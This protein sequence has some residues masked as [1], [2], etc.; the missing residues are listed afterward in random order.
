MESYKSLGLNNG[1][2]HRAL[3]V[4][5]KG[6]RTSG[7]MIGLSRALMLMRDLKFYLQ[8]FVGVYDI[9]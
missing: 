7:R 5:A 3:H 6:M 4:Y 2:R 8:V 1:N 9:S